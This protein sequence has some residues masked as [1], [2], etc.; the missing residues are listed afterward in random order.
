MRGGRELREPN[1]LYSSPDP[2]VLC[3]QA[4]QE[5]VKKSGWPQE[6]AAS[7]VGLGL[8]AALTSLGVAFIA[9]GIMVGVA[10]QGG[11]CGHCLPACSA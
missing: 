5:P 11:G 7:F 1:P 3:F 6:T 4:K 9:R 8:T 2:E 10:S